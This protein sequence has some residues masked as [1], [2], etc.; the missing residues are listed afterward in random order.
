MSRIA[1]EINNLRNKFVVQVADLMVKLQADCL[2]KNIHKSDFVFVICSVLATIIG[3]SVGNFKQ[4]SHERAFELITDMMKHAASELTMKAEEEMTE[5]EA[6]AHIAK[7]I[8]SIDDEET[9]R[10]AALLL[11]TSG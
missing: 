8:N 5:P 7:F 6:N 3:A 2:D 1:P 11:K 4:G 9:R 10:T